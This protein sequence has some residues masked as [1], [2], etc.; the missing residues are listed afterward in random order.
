LP[1]KE[2]ISRYWSANFLGELIIKPGRLACKSARAF[3]S[4][5]SDISSSSSPVPAFLFS[6]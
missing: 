3:G 4:M 6:S 2:I 1:I 5:R